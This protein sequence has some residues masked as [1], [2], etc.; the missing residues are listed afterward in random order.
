MTLKEKTISGLIWSVGQQFGSKLISF[1]ITIVLARILTPAE[2]G[3]IAMLSVFIS[4][5]NTLLD[6]GLTSSLIRTADADQKD[7]STVFY[8]NLIGS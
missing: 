6:S 1:F 7:F 2:F 5:G 4:I 8:F 3:L